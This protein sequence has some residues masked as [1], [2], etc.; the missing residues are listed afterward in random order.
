MKT[1]ISTI[2]G[3]N[4]DDKIVLLRV[5]FN[6]PFDKNT[7]EISDTTRI[8]RSLPTIQ[9]LLNDGAALVI[10]SHLGRPKG[11]D[12]SLSLEPV[13]KKLAEL[14]NQEIDFSG[15]IDQ[16]SVKKARQL[17]AGDILVLENLR[18][19]KE[20]TSKEIA[21]RKGFAELLAS[22]ADAYVDDAFGACH[23]E[24]AS[25]FDIA[26]LLPSYAGL[27]LKKEIDILE[28]IFSKAE[29]PF[30]AI[31]G[32]AKVSSKIGVLDKLIKKVD[33]VLIGG[34][35]AYTFLKARAI[36]VGNSLTE[37]DYYSKAFQIVDK[38]DYHHCQLLLPED[39]IAGSEFSEKAKK[40]TV[41]REVPNGF[42]G[43]DIG[44]KTIDKYI[45]VIKNAKTVL[46]N[47]PMGVFEM[48]PFS[49][50]TMKIAKALTKVKG[51][52]IIGGGDSIA[53]V[54]QAGVADKMTHISTGGGA[55]LEFLEGRK[56]PGIEALK[57]D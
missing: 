23:R 39:H 40:K 26:K 49:K 12:K 32:G 29:K 10:M 15:S 46:W 13:A 6:V 50:G 30:V 20:E 56:L 35:M 51:T 37:P 2:E 7:G 43:L 47:G 9:Y 57:N 48:K 16:E 41:G 17:K 34:G 38:A 24:H 55:K 8:E 18:Y 14:L 19:Y 11:K 25:I 1:Q 53:A 27:L 21:E 52:T 3:L 44:P 42:M 36:E 22:H 5:D 28:M 31:I 4:V 54:N 45:K 33:S